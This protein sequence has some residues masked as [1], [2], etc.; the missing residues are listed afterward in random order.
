VEGVVEDV[1]RNSNNDMDDVDDIESELS[2]ADDDVCDPES[3]Y[4]FVWFQHGM[5]LRKSCMIV[6]ARLRFP[7]AMLAR[8]SSD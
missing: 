1:E 4:V 2:L 8:K 3:V 6:I 7:R 5:M